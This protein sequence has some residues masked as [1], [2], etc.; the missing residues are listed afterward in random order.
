[1]NRKA[2]LSQ[3]THTIKLM[4]THDV[5]TITCD[6]AHL[7]LLEEVRKY[8]QKDKPQEM[9]IEG[10][11]YSWWYVC[12]ECHGAIDGNDHFCRWCGQAVINGVIRK[13]EKQ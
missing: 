2:L 3:L 7:K 6:G 13:E 1:M 12:P 5:M 4:K 9:E 8:M 10:G 11:G